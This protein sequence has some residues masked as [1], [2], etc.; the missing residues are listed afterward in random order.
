MPNH[1]VAIVV[2][3]LREAPSIARLPT[4][5]SNWRRL[6]WSLPSSKS[7]TFHYIAKIAK[8]LGRRAN[9]RVFEVR[10]KMSMPFCL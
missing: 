9:G 5:L 3:S 4:R 2:G 10:S 8:L 7:A 6:I 1:K